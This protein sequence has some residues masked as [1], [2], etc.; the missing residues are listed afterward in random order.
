MHTPFFRQAWKKETS[1][2]IYLFFIRSLFYDAFSVTKTFRVE[3]QSDKPMM[4][5]KDS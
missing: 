5:R 2:K 3:W 4:I 1:S